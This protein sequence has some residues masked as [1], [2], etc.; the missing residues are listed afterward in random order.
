HGHGFITMSSA[1]DALRMLQERGHLD[2]QY[3]VLARNP[4]GDGAGVYLRGVAGS[5]DQEVQVS[6]QPVF[7]EDV[8]NAVK[9]DF[10]R[11]FEP[12]SEDKWVDVPELLYTS[13]QGR[14]MPVRVSPADLGPGLHSTRVLLYDV[15]QPRDLGPE[16]IIPVTVV[17][18]ERTSSSEEHRYAKHFRL[19]PGELTRTF[20]RV[21]A[22]AHAAKIRVVQEGGGRNEIRAG[23]G[24]VSGTRYA[25]DRQARG[26]F[27][28]EDGQAYETTVPVEVGT[29]LEYTMASRW[30][31]NTTAKFLLEVQ[32]VGVLPHASEAV[33][34]AGQDHG[35][36]AWQSLLADQNVQI[37]AVVKGYA[38]PVHAPIEVMPD[39]IRA[40]LGLGKRMFQGMRRWTVDVPEGG[41]DLVMRMPH[42]IQTTELREDLMLIVRDA[43]GQ[44][45]HRHIAYEI[46]TD[47]GHHEAGS[48]EFEMI[49]PAL[50]ASMVQTAYAGAEVRFLAG[51][52]ACQ[53]ADNLS[54]AWGGA[55][56]SRLRI[57][58]GGSRLAVLTP[59]KLKSLDEGAY[60]FGS[61][62]A[63]AGEITVGEAELRVER[64]ALAS[65]SAA[66][67][68]EP[69][70][71]T[72]SL[73][74]TEE[75]AVSMAVM[76]EI[77]EG[78]AAQ[79]EVTVEENVDPA[80]KAAA[81]YQDACMAAGTPGGQ[82]KRLA[83][84]RGW[85]KAANMDPDAELAIYD[86][87][88]ESGMA[89]RAIH[90]GRG[91]LARFPHEIDRFLSHA[92]RWHQAR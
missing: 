71:E 76:D 54:G 6:I 3:Q 83:A 60:W 17:I 45:L 36:V 69:S 92:A 55:S 38:Q 86:S 85:Q 4:F 81:A 75:V 7:E 73:D 42:S 82:V 88:A 23:S 72:D 10:L 68:A 18:P 35:Y 31:T 44:V 14:S 28:L 91:F 62:M 58:F 29:V 61:V 74:A 78:E 64:P 21:P 15:D 39:P 56:G 77:M 70:V 53:I 8:P 65:D 48:Y 80:A 87:L 11:T 30:A 89:S 27:F 20:L 66:V 49:I 40:E 26:R 41:C 52:G 1:L 22:G 90:L 57:P 46:D 13:A 32:F 47:L 16:L 24:S 2:Q 5:Q 12:V 43:K 84:A 37:S 67:Q 9:A 63:Q 25:G 34:P 33:I 79:A 19:Q 50:G 51:G 59:P